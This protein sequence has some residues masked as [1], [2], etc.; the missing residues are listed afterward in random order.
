MVRI[1]RAM[2]WLL[3]RTETTL[4]GAARRVYTLRVSLYE[5]WLALELQTLG[6]RP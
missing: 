1:Y 4:T 5:R 2:E 6:R 3:I